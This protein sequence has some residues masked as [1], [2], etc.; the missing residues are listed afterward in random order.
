[1]DEEECDEVELGSICE[2]LYGKR[3]TQKKDQGTKYIAYGGGNIMSYKVDEYNRDGITYKISRDGLSI[4]NCIMRIY[5]K[6]FLNDTALSLNSKNIN[7][8]NNYIGEFL[9]SKKEYIYKNCSHGSTQLH[10]DLDRLIKIKLKIP[11]NKKIIK[12]IEPLFHELEK[13]QSEIKEANNKYK[14]LTEKLFKDFKKPEIINNLQ[15]NEE[16]L[17]TE[18]D[19]ELTPESEPESKIVSDEESEPEIIQKVKPKIATNKVIVEPKITVKSNVLPAV[20]KV[21]KNT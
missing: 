8:T 4:H 15:S 14:E 1:M 5:G 12:D 17:S 13:L 21:I 6:I 2:I 3:I 16:T 19:E 20:K 11:K 18:S 9:L 7:I 10:I